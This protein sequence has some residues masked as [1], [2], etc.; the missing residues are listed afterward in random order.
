MPA[1]CNNC[2]NADEDRT[3]MYCKK[4]SRFVAIKASGPSP[5]DEDKVKPL[6]FGSEAM[7]PPSKGGY[8]VE[9]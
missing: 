4:G 5:D 3:C 8:D 6:D 7:F 9:G 1:Y 2:S